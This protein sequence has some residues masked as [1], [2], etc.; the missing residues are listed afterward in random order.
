MFG[1]FFYATFNSY[2]N[3]DK[4]LTVTG[5]LQVEVTGYK[6]ATCLWILYSWI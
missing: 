1:D 3:T 4:Y 5:R 6:K 2:N